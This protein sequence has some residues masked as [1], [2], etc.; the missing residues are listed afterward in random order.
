MKSNFKWGYDQQASFEALKE[1]LVVSLILKFSKCE[2]EFC[3]ETNASL[4]GLGAV[5]GQSQDDS[6][7]KDSF[8]VV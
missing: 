4:V 2:K 3:V 8:T 1:H 7:F 6:G 5:L